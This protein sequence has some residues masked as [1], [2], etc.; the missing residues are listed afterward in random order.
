MNAWW[1]PCTAN[2]S[3]YLPRKGFKSQKKNEKLDHMCIDKPAAQIKAAQPKT[4]PN[5]EKQTDLTN[6]LFDQQLLRLT[7]PK[8][9]LKRSSRQSK[10]RTSTTERE[11]SMRQSSQSNQ[12][13]SKANITSENIRVIWK[14]KNWRILLPSIY[15]HEAF[16]FWP[17][18]N[19]TNPPAMLPKVSVQKW[20]W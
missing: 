15:P 8:A 13:I 16:V 6:D 9:V 2:L 19:K 1:V 14:T 3:L 17:R 7:V 12:K 5:K 18:R 11:M 20:C 4:T 10:A